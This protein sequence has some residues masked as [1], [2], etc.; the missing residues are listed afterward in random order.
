MFYALHTSSPQSSAW[1]LN[2][3][4]GRRPPSLAQSWGEMLRSFQDVPRSNRRALTI[5]I[6]L[7]GVVHADAFHIFP[8]GRHL[9]QLCKKITKLQKKQGTS[10]ISKKANPASV[11]SSNDEDI[12]SIQGIKPM[13]LS[14]TLAFF[15]ERNQGASFLEASGRLAWRSLLACKMC[16]C[17]RNW[18]PAFGS[19]RRN[20]AFKPVSRNAMPTATGFL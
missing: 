9:H 4:S 17:D 5:G 8:W 6:A 7:V 15:S 1:R 12:L 14:K 20:K 18:W 13:S 19:H 3:A 16:W 2:I 11:R 10:Y